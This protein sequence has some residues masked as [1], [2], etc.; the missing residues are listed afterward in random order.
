MRILKIL[1]NNVVTTKDTDT[2]QEKVIM[3]RGIAFQKKKGE[4]IDLNKIEKVFSIENQNDNQ[5]F[6]KLVDEIP[7]EH[8]EV[9]EE[10]IK[11]AEEKLDRKFYR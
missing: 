2:G 8:I 1:N 10:V 7:I 6:Q 9:S 11:Y 3:G 5:K 4:K